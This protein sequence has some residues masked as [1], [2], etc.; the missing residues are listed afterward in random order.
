MSGLPSAGPQPPAP[1]NK[2]VATRA[3]LPPHDNYTFCNASAP[4]EVRVD[5]LISQL[6]EDEITLF[7]KARLGGGCVVRYWRR[8]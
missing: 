4:L 2:T 8:L 3:C 7:M 5:D 6:H 1:S